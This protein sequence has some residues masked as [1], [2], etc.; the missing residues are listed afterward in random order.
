[1]TA[2]RSWSVIIIQLLKEEYNIAPKEHKYP[3]ILY[4]YLDN[5]LFCTVKNLF[6]KSAARPTFLHPLCFSRLMRNEQ[7]DLAEKKLCYK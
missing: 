6:N 1:M 2:F 4:G 5:W 7:K 3:A